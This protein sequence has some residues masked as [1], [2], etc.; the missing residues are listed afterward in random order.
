MNIVFAPRSL[1]D[2]E[3]IASYLIERSEPGARHVLAAIKTSIEALAFF[4]EI[5]PRIDESGHRRLP[6]HRY[7]YV[8]FYRIQDDDLLILHIRHSSRRPLESSRQL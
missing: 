8:I 7:P 6:V 4:P 2:L 3:G 5:G 1:R